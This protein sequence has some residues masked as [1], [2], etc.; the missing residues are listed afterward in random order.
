MT[1]RL[2]KWQKELLRLGIEEDKAVA[3]RLQKLYS[4]NLIEI[5]R[6]LRTYSDALDEDA[7]YWKQLRYG[8]LRRL[9][10]ELTDL[11]TDVA[12]KATGE[13]RSF[14]EA[15]Y[16][17][18]Y[19]EL[20]YQ[21][22][23][24]EQIKLTYN[25]PDR[26]KIKAI[27]DAPID[28]QRLS[29]RLYKHRRAL[30]DVANHALSFDIETGQGYKKIANRMAQVSNTSYHNMLRIARTEGKRVYG[31]AKV[32]SFEEAERLGVEGQKMW[33]ATLDART[34]SSHQAL[35]GQV[36]DYN[37]PFENNGY[38]AQAPGLFGVASED[39]NCR[40]QVI[41]VIDG[42][43]PEY[44]RD[45]ETGEVIEFQTYQEW[46]SSKTT[47]DGFKLDLQFFGNRK[48]DKEIIE[49]RIANGMLDGELFYIRRKE[50]NDI[51]SKGVQT[52]IETVYNKGDRY[53][54]IIQRHEKDLFNDDGIERI[55]KSLKEP[56]EIRV[57][58]DFAGRK[59]NCYIEKTKE[60]KIPLVSIVRNGIVTSY[61]PDEG[62][63][64]NTILKKGELVYEDNNANDRL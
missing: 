60:N 62:Y 42:I 61:I 13:V 18:G 9:E 23:Q 8:S 30:A 12:D 43:K 15:Q 45:G 4:N 32:D 24:K 1:Q 59:A 48:S 50:F 10:S 34:R 27:A 63:Y 64:K 22:E 41:D 14:V 40:C 5:R 3:K 57:T 21:T 49:E 29:Q 28:G 26:R 6:L 11:L 19:D 46:K 17:R 52:P 31:Q 51:F 33:L 38:T 54:H 7:P 35:D 2:N 56:N 44:R 25:L 16:E 47:N 39:I 20:F 55:V 58:R 36:K 53:Y 37:E